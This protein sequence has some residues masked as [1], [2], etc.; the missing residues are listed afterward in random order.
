[1][2]PMLASTTASI[3]TGDQWVHEVKWDGMRVLADVTA[4]RL[5][6]TSRTERDVTVAFPELL[7]LADQYEDLLLDGE[8]VVL[9]GG[10]PSFAALAERF[11]VTDARKAARLAAAKPVTY[12]AFD[13]LR[14]YGVDLTPR[15]WSD[16]RATLDRLE[17]ATARWQTPPTFTDGATLFAATR[18]QGLEGVVSKRKDSPY[19]PGQ[20]SPYWLKSPHRHAVSVVIGG[21]RPEST[22][23]SGR[24][25]GAVLVGLPGPEGLRFAGRVGA[26]LAGAAGTALLRRLG[27]LVVE[28]SPFAVPVPTVDALGARWVRPVLVADVESLGL[29]SGGRLRQPAWKGLRTDLTPEELEPEQLDLEPEQPG[30]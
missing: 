25:L 18:E 24:R 10:L 17:L 8:V 2:R 13:L 7:G 29:G 20:R 15:S 30:E 5:R 23:P 27:G 16:R 12:M 21:W 3:P 6:L 11:H 4:G 14:L 9:E 28:E 19:R 26:G 22:D 1:M